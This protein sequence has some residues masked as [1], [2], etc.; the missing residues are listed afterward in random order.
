M[1]MK[2]SPSPTTEWNDKK[3]DSSLRI[4]ANPIRRH[5]LWQLSQENDTVATIDELCDGL[6]VDGSET[7]T[8]DEARI[9]LLHTHLPML[10][11]AGI[12]DVDW[13]RETVRYRS[14]HRIESLLG[15]IRATTE[16]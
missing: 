15:T 2:A 6:L 7:L 3:L 10:S 5:L 9:A 14:G 13:E 8:G 4:L 11:D 12:V 1:P 16:A